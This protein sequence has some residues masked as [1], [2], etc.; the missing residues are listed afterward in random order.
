MALAPEQIEWAE[1]HIGKEMAVARG[2]CTGFEVLDD[3]RIRFTCTDGDDAA[4]QTVT[5]PKTQAQ[6]DAI[7]AERL[8][9]EKRLR[10]E[11][12]AAAEAAAAE[13]SS[14]VDHAVQAAQLGDFAELG[15]LLKELAR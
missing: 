14:R 4:T 6:L 11:A 7:E 12:A 5:P 8:A 1:D 9:E 10:D 13:T 2:T 3:D 15:T